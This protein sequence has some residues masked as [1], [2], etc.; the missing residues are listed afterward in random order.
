VDSHQKIFLIFGISVLIHIATFVSIH[1]GKELIPPKTAVKKTEAV[2]VK[3]VEKSEVPPPPKEEEKP[4]KRPEVSGAKKAS[5]TPPKRVQGL[6]AES[7]DDAPADSTGFVAPVGNTLMEKDLGQRLN[8]NEIAKLK[9]DLSSD[10]LLITSTFNEPK[11]TQ[12]AIDAALEGRYS[13]DVLVDTSGNVM[14]VEAQRRI[15]FGMDEKVIQA[16]KDAKFYP[17]K[18]ALG[19]PEAGWTVLRINLTLP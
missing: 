12:A 4:P 15:G 1:W 10:A 8:A 7:F 6:S 3:I 17:K 2:Q 5:T 18:N 13:F 16:I 19:V 14:D 11:Y 9:R